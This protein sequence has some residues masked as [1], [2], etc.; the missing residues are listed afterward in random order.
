MC[1]RQ[2]HCD[3]ECNPVP[4]GLQRQ[5]CLCPGLC[6]SPEVYTPRLPQ[7]RGEV[8]LLQVL[9][10]W[11]GKFVLM[12]EILFKIFFF[13]LTRRIK[14]NIPEEQELGVIYEIDDTFKLL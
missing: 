2:N 3:G 7:V 13:G 8:Q 4:P 6:P 1:D 14:E 11:S 5:V 12:S 9:P 10:R